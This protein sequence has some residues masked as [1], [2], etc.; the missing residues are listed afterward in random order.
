VLL[1]ARLRLDELLALWGL[2]FLSTTPCRS[3]WIFA[4]VARHVLAGAA[5]HGDDDLSVGGGV[6]FTG[7]LLAREPGGGVV[8]GRGLREDLDGLDVGGLEGG[9]EGE[10]CCLAP[11]L[12]LLLPVL[13]LSARSRPWVYLEALGASLGVAA[14]RDADLNLLCAY[15]GAPL[16][17]EP[18]AFAAT[19]D[20][21]L[22]DSWIFRASGRDDPARDTERHRENLATLVATRQFATFDLRLLTFIYVPLVLAVLTAAWFALPS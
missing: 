5:A 18:E 12:V 17:V 3:P 9:L 7:V 16:T 10:G 20:Y 2:C 14:R 15:C 13:V 6:G 1:S 11:L 19:C 22:A 8:R 4:E 21:C